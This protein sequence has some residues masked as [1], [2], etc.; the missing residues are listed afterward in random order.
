MPYY[1][2]MPTTTRH[3]IVIIIIIMM[4]PPVE[5]IASNLIH[6]CI[7]LTHT[8][9]VAFELLQAKCTHSSIKAIS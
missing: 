8:R 3:A 9:L 2:L 5:L 4:K 1:Y 6:V 7:S